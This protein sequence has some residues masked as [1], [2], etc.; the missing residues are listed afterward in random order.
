MSQAGSQTGSNPSDSESCTPTNND[1]IIL[2]ISTYED[3]RQLTL[4]FQNVM[5]R[6]GEILFLVSTIL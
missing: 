1:T 3:K 6:T 4:H 2:M 5:A